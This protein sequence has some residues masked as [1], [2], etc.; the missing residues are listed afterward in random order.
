MHETVTV[1]VSPHVFEFESFQVD[2]MSRRLLRE[3][4]V[5]PLTSRTF[6]ILLALI[7]NS[8]R[9]VEKEELMDRV[10]ADTF[11]EEGNLNR[12]ISMLRKVLGD[13]GHEQRF[14]RTVP[15]HG[16]RF[17]APVREVLRGSLVE[18]TTRVSLN[19]W[20]E[21]VETTPTR[22]RL[23]I[24]FGIL[25][26]IG[27]VVAGWMWTKNGQPANGR[28]TGHAEALALASEKGS[29]FDLYQQ[30]RTLWQ[31]RNGEDLHS[32]TLLLEQSVKQDPNFALAHAALA[33]AYAFDY[34]NWP[35][36]EATARTAIAI[37]PTLGEPHATIGFVKMFWEWKL[38]EAEKEFKQAVALSPNY[39]TGH[40]WYAINLFA[41][42]SGGSAALVELK[43][44]LQLEP[45]SVSINADMCQTLYFLRHY[46]E[47]A[48]QCQKTL[49]MNA[50]SFNAYSNL[51]EIYNAKGMYDEAVK[52]YFKTEELQ[53]Q[54][55]PPDEH[56]KIREAYRTGG[57]RAFWEARIEYLPYNVPLH[58]RIAQHYAR[59][60]KTDEAFDHLQK[61]YETRDFDFILFLAE[62]VFDD[63]RHDPRYAELRSLMLGNK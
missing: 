1:E 3:G 62:P 26:L 18:D 29:A 19:V 32:A 52:S 48:A 31:T 43:T 30:G 17:T 25:L 5:V 41:T 44:A 45:N 54:P 22:F 38:T 6:D 34:R 55:S 10:W 13:D 37:D 49:E 35:K 27:G 28:F 60:G 61:A 36:A 53:G 15:K 9:T 59:L 7:E 20:E 11:V 33:D 12:N 46:D 24:G 56:E 57:I 39:A 63:L 42:G 16:Y 40:Q 47:A 23:A 2:P 8:G 58:Y 50:K 21:T 51:Y 4:E 14:I